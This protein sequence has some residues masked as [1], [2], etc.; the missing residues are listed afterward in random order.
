MNEKLSGFLPCR[1]MTSW[2]N[3]EIYWPLLLIWRA[4][5]NGLHVK[6][7][8]PILTAINLLKRSMRRGPY[9]EKTSYSAGKAGLMSF[10]LFVYRNLWDSTKIRKLKISF[11]ICPPFNEKT[12]SFLYQITLFIGIFAWQHSKS[13]LSI[14][15]LPTQDLF[16]ILISLLR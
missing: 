11:K 7:A 16:L 14:F 10:N 4:F 12:V 2:I 15:A 3:S 6:Y 8:F 9:G 5:E 1:T 13:S